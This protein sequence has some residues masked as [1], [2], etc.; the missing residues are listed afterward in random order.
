MST[1]NIEDKSQQGK[2]EEPYDLTGLLL[3]FLSHWKWFV[4][5]VLICICCAYYYVSTI[6]PSY[7]VNA[8]IYLNDK[9]SASSSQALLGANNAMSEFNDFF[10]DETEIEILKSKNNLIKIVDSLDLAYSYYNVGKLRDVP[11]YRN[12]AILAKLDSISLRNLTHPIEI[13]IDK[14]DNEYEVTTTTYFN[15]SEEKKV[16]T[17][18]KF[19]A[20]IGLSQGTVTLSESPFTKKMDAVEKIVINNP[21]AVAGALANSLNIEFAKNSNAI[22]NL[23]LNTSV[24]EQ[25]KDILDVLVEFYNRQIIEDKNRSA[26]QTEA[27][28]LDRLVMI[29]GELKDVESRLRDYREAHNIA[30]LDAQTSMNLQQRSSTESQLANVDAEREIVNELENLVSHQDTYNQLP[31]LTN[32]PTLSQSIDTYNQAVSNYDRARE[33]MGADHPRIA[34]LQTSLNRQKSQIISN[35]NAAKRDINARRRSIV[36][37]DSRSSGQLAVQPTIDKGLN[38]IFREQQVKVNIYTYLLQKREEIALQKTLATP[39]AQFIDNP[40]DDGSVKPRRIIYLGIGFLIGLLIPAL[41]IYVKRML[42][43]TF[44]DKE[45]LQRVTSVPILGEICLNNSENDIVVGESV[46]SSIAELFRLLRNNLNFV[47]GANAEKKV[48]LVTSTISGEGKTFVASNLAMTYALTGKKTV[49]VG[50]DIRRPVLAHK[51]GFSNNTGVTTYLSGQEN[52]IEN[53]LH[54]SEQNDN[55]FILPAGPVPPN[56]NELLLGEKTSEL[57][58]QL[59]S[60]F[61]CVIIDSAPIGLV[62]DTYLIV[63]HS[64][65]QVYVARAGYSSKAGLKILH[66]AINSNRLTHPYIVLN[67][68]KV[69]GSAYVYRRY[70]H[71]GYYSN[72]A[73]TYAYG[74]NTRNKSLKQKIS[75]KKDKILNNKK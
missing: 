47:K 40:T 6:I 20:K 17:V 31:T 41:I 22:L 66:E 23:S 8:S 3:D 45:E 60:K 13:T 28:I 7:T 42:F 5:S 68:V 16:Q 19:P 56:P 52:D 33:S 11:V 75:D 24:I 12:S 25:G 1:E 36:S 49:I 70:G 44:N 15:N 54:Q 50:L 51:F 35:I 64:D 29:N 59:R 62:S 37:I 10:I 9:T 71:Y 73:Y 63:A 21:D 74:G 32:N 43:P 2:I 38:E 69:E 57:F 67:G 48:I 39:T 72:N 4:L 65:V 46:S 61:D 30:N 53:L 34:E 18:K 27:F 14:S 55:L 26:I 58:N